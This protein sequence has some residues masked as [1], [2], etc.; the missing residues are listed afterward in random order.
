MRR[1]LIIITAL[2]L[3][4]TACGC[5]TRYINKNT[6]NQASPITP[7][8]LEEISR[9]I[10]EGTGTNVP[11][12]DETEPIPED[13]RV[14]LSD[15]STVYWLS[16]GKVCHVSTTCRYIRERN[17]ALSGTFAEAREAGRDKVC[18]ICYPAN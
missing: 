17:D 14:P 4:L 7:E 6:F 5:T 16:G 11:T 13:T 2:T 10:F 8:M 15:D 9:E 12:S 18:S 3:L 1:I